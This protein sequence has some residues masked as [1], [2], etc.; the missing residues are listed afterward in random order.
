[1][2]FGDIIKKARIE[3]GL[4]QEQLSEMAGITSPTLGKI[5]RSDISSSLVKI[6]LV[7]D[8]LGLAVSVDVVQA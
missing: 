5:E 2:N 8:A 1:M 3:K 7:C 6:K 4:T